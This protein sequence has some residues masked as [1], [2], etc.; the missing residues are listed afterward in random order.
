M[1]CFICP[2]FKG[3]PKKLKLRCE[4]GNLKFPDKQ[5]RRFLVY[6]YCAHPTNYTECTFYK[7]LMDYYDR[8]ESEENG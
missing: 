2:F 7:L 1:N 8:K 4:I 3:E 5:A 6:G